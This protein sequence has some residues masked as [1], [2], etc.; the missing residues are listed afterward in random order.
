MPTRH[1][2]KDIRL[3]QLRSFCETA[4]LGSL[5]AAADSLGLAQPT[6]WE[7]VHALE[8]LLG[9]RLI[10]RRAH[11]SRL[12]ETGRLLAELAAPLVAGVDSLKRNLAEAREQ[13]EVRL[14]VAA[15]PRII[16][17]DL[18]PAVR[19]FQKRHPRVGLSLREM[20]N[21]AVTAVVESGEADLGLSVERPTE[22]PN[23]RLEFET[24]YEL[25]VILVTPRNHPLARK[26]RI[27]LE[28]LL[29]Y[30]VVNASH[31][32]PDR[33]IAAAL[34]KL[35]VF[36]TRPRKVEVTFTTAIR[37][38]VAE[39][40]G[41]GLIVGL[42][43][44]PPAPQLHERSLSAHLGRM[45]VSLVWRKGAVLQQGYARAFADTIITVLGRRPRR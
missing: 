32:Y 34:E 27:V 19:E 13:L 44:R 26:R 9:D 24:A 36:R 41:I 39:G 29:P 28:D 5:T 12:T 1:S 31:N 4:R 14:A 42:P 17:E 18:P 30:P 8:R 45:P 3:Q 15:P 23:P 35:G 20:T 40:F 7:Q 37:R 21:E 16:D 22:P 10:E 38:Y 6:V 25:D 43:T 11:G 2:Y 33:A